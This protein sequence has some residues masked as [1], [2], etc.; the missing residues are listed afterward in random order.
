MSYTLLVDETGT[1][2]KSKKIIFVGCLVEDSQLAEI[3]QS[4]RNFNED[5]LNQP[6]YSQRKS[7]VNTNNEAR[8]YVSDHF[9]LRELFVVKVLTRISCR[10]YSS[11]MNYGEM[12]LLDSKVALF[13][14]LIIK[15][16]ATKR[17]DNLEIV[18]EESE[19]AFQSQFKD[20]TFRSKEF[21]PLSIADYYAGMLHAFHNMRIQLINGEKINQQESSFDIRFYEMMHNQLAIEHDISTNEISSRRDG[22]IFYD[23]FSKL[24]TKDG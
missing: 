7:W 11:M 3:E 13:R 17:I 8:H 19:A 12:P 2:S 4:I 24:Y 16:S 14:D 22:R 10:V 18:A 9:T 1:D 5:L 6:G 21:L 15:A 23:Q 20:V